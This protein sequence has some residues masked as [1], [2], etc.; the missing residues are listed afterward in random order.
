MSETAAVHAAIE[1]AR[2]EDDAE[3]MSVAYSEAAD[4]YAHSETKTGKGLATKYR[5]LAEKWA[6]RAGLAEACETLEEAVF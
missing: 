6:T 4:H 2:A 3:L 5:N 1:E